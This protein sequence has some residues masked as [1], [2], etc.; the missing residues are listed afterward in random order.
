MMIDVPG[1][2][3]LELIETSFTPW[4]VYHHL[5]CVTV[6]IW[7]TIKQYGNGYELNETSLYSRQFW[8]C[9]DGTPQKPFEVRALISISSLLIN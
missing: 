6:Q 4:Y 2:I 1:V 7:S 9:L 3:S 8:A 5:V